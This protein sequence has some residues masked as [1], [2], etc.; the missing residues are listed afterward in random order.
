MSDYSPSLVYEYEVRNAFTPPLNYDDISKVDLLTKIE[1]VEDFIKHRYFDSSMPTRTQAKSAALMIV[2]SR[3]V[4][5]NPELA[6]KYSELQSLE[7]GDY[8]VA[9]N[10]TGRG[11]HVTAYEN[12]LSWEE[13]ALQ[14]LDKKEADAASWTTPVLVNG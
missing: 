6:K 1:L 9:F 2:M 14:I 11:K 8:K 10:T 12:A 5:G 3:V 13:M 7:L 4:R